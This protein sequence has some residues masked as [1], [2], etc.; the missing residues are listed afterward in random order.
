MHDILVDYIT[1]RRAKDA[2]VIQH[3][4]GAQDLSKMASDTH[5]HTS[6]TWINQNRSY[7]YHI[8]MVYVEIES[9]YISIN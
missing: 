6:P 1:T 8:G 3:Q 4:V 9:V 7:L 2:S 5:D